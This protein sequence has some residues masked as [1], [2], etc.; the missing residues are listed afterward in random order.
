MEERTWALVASDPSQP[1]GRASL[2]SGSGSRGVGRLPDAAGDR[3][4]QI[5]SEI[6]DAWAAGDSWTP[7]TQRLEELYD[8]LVGTGAAKK[9]ISDLKGRQREEGRGMQV[10]QTFS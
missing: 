6:L 10:S 7:R 9:L 3:V 1:P 2:A 8:S 5:R 4:P